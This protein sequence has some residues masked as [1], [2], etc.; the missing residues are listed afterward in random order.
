[1]SQPRP[2]SRGD[3]KASWQCEDSRQVA[4][5][6]EGEP[7]RQVQSRLVAGLGEGEPLRQIYDHLLQNVQ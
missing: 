3:G 4:G 6:A 5:L 7:L 1:M 2:T